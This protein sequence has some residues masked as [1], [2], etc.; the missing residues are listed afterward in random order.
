MPAFLN[1]IDWFF[2][3]HLTLQRMIVLDLYTRH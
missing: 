3:L 1:V 2:A